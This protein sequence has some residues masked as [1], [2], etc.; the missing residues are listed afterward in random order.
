MEAGFFFKRKLVDLMV[1]S[2]LIL[3]V[4]LSP[5]SVEER[6]QVKEA[7]VPYKLQ[8]QKK[9]GQLLKEY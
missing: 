4:K 3:Y 2:R 8:I 1:P 7:L 5:I 9:V 6:E